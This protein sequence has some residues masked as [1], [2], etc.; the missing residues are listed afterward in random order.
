M[1]INIY[2][3]IKGCL[4]TLGCTW[5]ESN[6]IVTIT[7]PDGDVWDFTIPLKKRVL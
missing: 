6:G 1:T 4:V 3:I 2:N 5:S 7:T